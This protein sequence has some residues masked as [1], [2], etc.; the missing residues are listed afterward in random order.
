MKLRLI[1]RVLIALS[2][3]LL[4]A[5]AAWMA[6][7]ALSI[8]PSL[9]EFLAGLLYV[10]AESPSRAWIAAGVCAVPALLGVFDFC[11]LLRRR[12]GKRGFIA[13]RSENGEI[14]ISVK[15]IETLVVKCAQKHGEIAVQSVA[16]EEERS[17]LL[18]K[19][20]AVLPSG[21]NIP[22]AV[23]TLQKQIKQ[24]IT[25]C[26]GVDVSEVRVKVETTDRPVENS[27]YAVSDET[28]AL[29][30]EQPEP[31]PTPAEA[32][33]PVELPAEEPEPI[34]DEREQH[35]HQR[36][37]S[38]PEEPAMVPEP[39]VAEPEDSESVFAEDVSDEE[40]AVDP[41]EAGEIEA[42]YPDSEEQEGP[43]DGSLTADELVSLAESRE[44]AAGAAE[45]TA[46]E[47][48]GDIPAE[49]VEEADP[50]R[51]AEPDEYTE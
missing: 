29:P 46:P 36:L 15:T 30:V 9:S 10:D 39:P 31:A 7:D 18:I 25:A 35:M 48:D 47:A 5:L 21:M 20:R 28:P 27:L 23:G 43:D 51:P 49:P 44:S 40:P 41:D 50:E 12:K 32:V 1:D 24:Y 11:V 4:M 6:L 19:L 34:P 37:F 33:A 2:G 8:V 22:L 3:L 26:S 45:E 38:T 17:G 14:A 16:V 42:L 13:Q